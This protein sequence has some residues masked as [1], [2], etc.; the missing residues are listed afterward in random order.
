MPVKKYFI[1]IVIPQPL[2]DKIEA[3]KNSLLKSHQLKCA[4][5]SPSHITLHRPFV[6]KEEKEKILIESLSS[7]QFEENFEVV[8]KNYNFFEPRVIYV[9]VCKNEILNK[10]HLQLTRFAKQ[11]LRLFNDVDDK[12]GFHP[13]VTIAFRDIKKPLFPVLKEKFI[14]EELNGT[15]NYQGFTL[16]KFSDKWEK[17]HFFENKSLSN[18]ITDLD[19][20]NINN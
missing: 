7:F 14:S 4:L 10:L 5:R 2:F 13:H 19:L 15:F 20:K 8:L 1:A 17:A 16:L 18:N 3:V 12:R 11:K 6:W 9:D